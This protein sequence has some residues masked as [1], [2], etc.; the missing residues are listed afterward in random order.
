MARIKAAFR[1]EM[2]LPQRMVNWILLVVIFITMVLPM[3]NVVAVSLST[4]YDSMAP[5]L[6]LLPRTLS[7]HGYGVVWTTNNLGRAFFNSCFVSVVST[8]LTILLC[9]MAG[10]VLIQRDLP[11]RHGIATIILV[12]LMIPGDLTLIS[13]YSLNKQLG[14]LNSYAG[15]IINGLAS[16]FAIMLM[17]NYFLSVPESLAESGRLDHASEMRIFFAIYIP[18][19]LPGLA[20]ITF[21]HFIG[22]WNALMTP[23]AIIT[24]LRLQTLPVV[25]RRIT[26]ATD[27]TSG[28][29]YIAPNA[30][31]AAIV[32]TIL[33]LIFLYTF[34]QRFLIG[35]L[36]LGASKG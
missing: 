26:N 8:F 34:A 27:S 25:L 23:L 32:I 19:S 22:N 6:K 2:T 33:P 13:M 15:L 1:N 3:L 36:T 11:Y 5:G 10:Y 9:S 21:L 35:G 20:S 12:T 7:L 16:G 28:L 24:D 29:E 17:R 18:L 30:Q 31:M 4:D 14:L